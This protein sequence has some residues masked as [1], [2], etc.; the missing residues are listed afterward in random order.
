MVGSLRAVGAVATLLLVV[1][2]GCSGSS[3]KAP[4]GTLADDAFRPTPNGFTFQNYGDTLDDGSTPTN[5]TAA[6]VETMFGPNVCADAQ[7][8]RCDL[9]PSAQSWLDM[10]NQEIDGGHCYGFSVASELLWQGKLNVDTFG[11]PTTPGLDI[12][13]NTTLQSQIAYDWTMQTLNSVQQQ[14]VVGT[15]NQILSALRR[16]LKPNP[17]ETYTIVIWKPDFTGGHAITPYAVQNLGNGNFKVYIYD[18]NWPDTTRA[19]SF[20]TKADTWTY[21]AASNPNEPDEV[22]HG[23]AKS[24]TVSLYPTN[25]GLG[26]QQCPFC[27]KT[28][29]KLTSG[30]AGSTGPM[31][32]IYLTGG[33]TNRANLVITDNAGQQLGVVGGSL[34][35]QIP[36]AQ[37][38][39]VIASQTWDD[40][41]GPNF[42]VPANGTYSIALDGTGL[43]QP[44]IETLGIIGP[45][46]SM[47]VNNITVRPGEKDTLVEQPDGTGMRFSSSRSQF[48]TLQLGVSD[49]QA[50]YSFAISGLSTQP[51]STASLSL[52]AESG[53]LG[54]ST[55]GSGQASNVN[56][57]MTRYTAKG[58]Q[59]FNHNGISLGTGDTA[60]LQ[61]GNWTGAGQAIPLITSH[62]GQ[63]FTQSLSNQSTATSGSGAATG[64]AGPQGPTGAPGAQGSA[65][66]SGAQGAPGTTGPT[67]TPGPTGATGPPGLPGITNGWQGS[68][69]DKVVSVGDQATLITRTPP[70]PSGHYAVTA[71]LSAA[72]PGSSD[73]RDSRDTV[74]IACWATPNSAGIANNRDGV[75]VVV[76]L[77]SASQSLNLTDLV[78]TS[79]SGD[80][81]DLV[82]SL[83]AGDDSSRDVATVAHASIIALQI[84][85]ITSTDS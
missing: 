22:Y 23:T 66:Q 79:V 19:I 57:Q 1:A 21:D 70:L 52:P 63:R 18:N 69:L 82:C 64:A 13:D 73:S 17:P 14:R 16:V 35:S 33:V 28:P 36:G 25:P 84:T 77:A 48:P 75:R 20:D 9:I 61:F 7:A 47:S 10:I 59:T 11:A 74:E 24:N 85:S 49:D 26:I 34:I 2:A 12:R 37:T 15:P 78:T 55:T 62:D 83:S 27:A 29:K 40:K 6:D 42:L 80:E 56:L 50:D 81:I 46:F 68:L 41:I 43:S 30:A 72:G 54:V 51:G 31:E 65:G 71:D 5:L 32:E 38:E 58:L 67:G 45:S 53:T 76:E 4:L 44:D 60:D 8:G 39:P 3:H